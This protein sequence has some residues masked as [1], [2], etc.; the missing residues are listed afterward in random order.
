MLSSASDEAGTGSV[1]LCSK[2][3]LSSN[4]RN[5]T[6]LMGWLWAKIDTLKSMATKT[7]S[8]FII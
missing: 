5:S 2:S 3:T 1:L 8:F 6:V 7:A 4:D